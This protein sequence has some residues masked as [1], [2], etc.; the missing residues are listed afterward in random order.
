MHKNSIYQTLKWI[1]SSWCFLTCFINVLK[2]LFYQQ[3]SL[4]IVNSVRHTLYNIHVKSLGPSFTFWNHSY[5]YSFWWLKCIYLHKSFRAYTVFRHFATKS[6]L[7]RVLYGVVT[8][9]TFP[10]SGQQTAIFYSQG[11]WILIL[12]LWVP[13]EQSDT[14]QI[15]K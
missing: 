8:V 12:T 9:P 15:T 1:C 6:Q 4:Y 2:I 14:P 11:W 7:Q 13:F 3:F 10:E 5:Q